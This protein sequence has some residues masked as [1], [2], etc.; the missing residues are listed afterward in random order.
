MR[1]APEE[2]LAALTDMAYRARSGALVAIV[3]EEATL[4]KCLAQLAQQA[5]PDDVLET[6][7][8]YDARRIGADVLWSV[9]LDNK[10]ADLNRKLALVLA[11]KANEARVLSRAFGRAEATS[12]LADQAKSDRLDKRAKMLQSEFEAQFLMAHYQAR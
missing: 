3:K 8:L 10:R 11:R 7:A 1:P 12:Y 9:W 6:S 2:E 5:R 4:R